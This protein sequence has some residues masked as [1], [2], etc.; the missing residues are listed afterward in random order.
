MQAKLAFVK[1][2]VFRR[3]SGMASFITTNN[4]FQ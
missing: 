3:V 1:Q 4:K 2:N